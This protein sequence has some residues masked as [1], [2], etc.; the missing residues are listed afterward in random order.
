ML[1]TLILLNQLSGV[2]TFLRNLR[3][4]LP[5]SGVGSRESGVGSRGKTENNTL[6]RV[7]AIKIIF[8]KIM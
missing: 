4:S 6:L 3:Q 1:E 7:L 5:E 8:V 2:L